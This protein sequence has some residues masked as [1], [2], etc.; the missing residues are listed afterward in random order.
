M[1]KRLERAHPT[2]WPTPMMMERLSSSVS[3]MM[4]WKLKDERSSSSDVLS[5]PIGR[6]VMKRERVCRRQ[7]TPV[8]TSI[9][10][11]EGMLR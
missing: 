4:C 10:I 3:S 6:S 8:N 11:K 2:T 1:H 5:I 9:Y 7:Q